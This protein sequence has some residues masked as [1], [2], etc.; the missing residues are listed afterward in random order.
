MHLTIHR[1]EEKPLGLPNEAF[2][3]TN[4]ER[5]QLSCPRKW[6]FSEVE[7]LR[8]K[9]ASDRPLR[10]GAA[11]AQ[12]IEDVQRWWMEKDLAY[13]EDAEMVC[14][15]C[16]H[17]SE[18]S[19]CNST[20]RGPAAR[21]YYHWDS[22][23]KS[24]LA[25]DDNWNP[26]HDLEGLR[27]ALFG[28]FR[29]SGSRSVPEPYKVVGVECAFAAP[30]RDQQG[31]ILLSTQTLVRDVDN[32][33]RVFWRLARSREAHADDVKTV[34]W[35]VYQIGKLD[36]LWQDRTTGDLVIWEGKTSQS[37]E[38]YLQGLS[39]DPQVPGYAWLLGHHLEAYGAKRVAGFVYDITSSV[40]QA[41][42]AP[43]A[44]KPVQVLDENGQPVKKGARY[45]YET[46]AEGNVIER[47]PGFSLAK[48]S[49]TVP[50]WRFRAALKMRPEF[51]AALYEEHVAALEQTVDPKLYVREFATVGPEVVRR[52]AREAFGIAMRIFTMRQAAAAMECAEDSDALFPRVPVCRYGGTVRCGWRA[53]CVHDGADVRES[54]D[55]DSAHKWYEQSPV[56]SKQA[57]KA[58]SWLMELGW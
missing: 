51:N 13:P 19:K 52:Y 58:D 40:Y 7:A 41:D 55:R 42:P 10:Y 14:A 23:Q 3:F 5:G 22:L 17:R 18:C 57:E 33:S 34:T 37:A 15:W 1:Y 35:P 49:G 38:G 36:A 6:W 11:W 21:A 26:E 30:I 8:P 2:T 56:D 53:P 43:L 12:I 48:T 54:F 47:S 31:Q 39:V 4:S 32:Q 50:S 29:R 27:R 9:Q 16:N 28:W 46:D 44:P 25:S 20:G 24:G 45:V